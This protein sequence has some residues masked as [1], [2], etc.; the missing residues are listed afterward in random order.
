MVSAPKGGN[1]VDQSRRLR[2]VCLHQILNTANVQPI[3][4]IEVWEATN[5]GYTMTD[6]SHSA[7]D[8]YLTAEAQAR[9]QI[10]QDPEA[11]GSAEY[12]TYSVNLAPPNRDCWVE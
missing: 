2:R 10:D 7:P 4:T 11:S 6:K 8:A 12:Y 3:E 5:A 9:V 1:R